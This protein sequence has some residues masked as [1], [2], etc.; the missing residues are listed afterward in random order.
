M[1]YKWIGAALIIGACGGTGYS[2]GAAYRKEEQLLRNTLSAMKFME[3]E[4][5]YR[6]TPLP[7][8]C[9]RTARMVKGTVGSLLEE[10]A[11]Q[12][13]KQLFP[14]ASDCMLSAINAHPDLP[15]SLRQICRELGRS[16]GQLDLEGQ[17]AGLESACDLCRR[18]IAKLEHN[19]DQRLRSYQ[20]LGICAGVALAIL[21]I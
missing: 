1:T 5:Q 6:L 15:K 20:T 4:L 18:K 19:R 8:L 13:E 16:L 7:Q 21:L 9:R 2:I 11:L 17:L 14:E 10:L 3:S 12:L